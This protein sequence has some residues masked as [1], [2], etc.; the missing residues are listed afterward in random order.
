MIMD[1]GANR[2]PSNA[3][4]EDKKNTRGLDPLNNEIG[5][6]AIAY[7]H[8]CLRPIAGRKCQH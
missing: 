3:V 6:P 1:D 8:S 4:L 7:E 5:H 2:T